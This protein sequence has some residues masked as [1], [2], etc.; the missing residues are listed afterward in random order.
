MNAKEA[1]LTADKNNGGNSGHLPMMFEIKQEVN[2]GKYECEYWHEEKDFTEEMK[3]TL[4]QMGYKIADAYE[5]KLAD[6]GTC[7]ITKISW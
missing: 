2:K 1:R 6:G 5:H 4:I 3:A 7:L